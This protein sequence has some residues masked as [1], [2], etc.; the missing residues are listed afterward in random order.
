MESLT[1]EQL[2]V[3]LRDLMDWARTNAPAEEPPLRKRIVAHLGRDPAELPVVSRSISAWERVNLQVALDA[4]LAESGREHEFVGM[5]SQRGWHM[6]LAELAAA[7][8]T[9]R[10][11]IMGGPGAGPQEH[12]AVQV[13]ERTIICVAAGLFLIRSGEERVVLAVRGANESRGPERDIQLEVLAAT[14]E[15]AEQLL[16]EISRLMSVHNVYR[17]RVLEVGGSRFGELSLEVR[18]LPRVEREAIVLPAGLLERIERHTLGFAEQA[19]RLR[20]AGRHIKRGL[21]LYGPPGTGKTLT[22]MYLAGQMPERTVLILTGSGLHAIGSACRIARQLAPSM[23]VMED[24]DLVALDRDEHESNALLFELLNEMDGMQEDLDVIFALTTNRA[25]RLEP[26]LA[27]RPGRVDLACELPIPDADGRRRLLELYGNGL[28][29]NA[30]DLPSLVADTDGASPAFIRELLRRAALLASEQS[31]AEL[32]VDA[33][34][35][36]AALRELTSDGGPL[37]ARLLG[38]G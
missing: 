18:S 25:D 35:L 20:S 19:D 38:M 26:A 32:V 17:G 3:A 14:R 16:E 15:P 12:E 13:G 23:V 31:G 4:Y 1:A 28:Q 22:A 36:G 29:L 7:A 6:G 34:V 33:V 37:T 24:V 21:L 9:Q 27:A 2:A 30:S 11:V 5:S 10:T 8:K